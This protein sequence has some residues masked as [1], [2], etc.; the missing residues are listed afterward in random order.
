MQRALDDAGLAPGDVQYVNA[1]G[2]STPYNDAIETKALKAVFGASAG[3]L[4][5]SSTK[6][7]TGHMLGAAGAFEAVATVL[8]IARRT[9]PPTAN[10]ETPDP[11]CD[12]DYVPG[13]PREGEIRAALS[14]SFGF[15]GTNACLAF[16]AV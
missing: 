3:A 5:V 8:A 6:G 9:A 12:L 16:T 7:C 1:H 10:Y 14:N 13:K 15:G 11:E 4:W 2:T